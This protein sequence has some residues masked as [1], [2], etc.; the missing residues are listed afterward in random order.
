MTSS[1]MIGSFPA[2]LTLTGYFSNSTGSSATKCRWLSPI[3]DLLH[4]ADHVGKTHPLAADATP[5]QM[6][7][8]VAK[9]INKEIEKK[10]TGVHLQP[11]AHRQPLKKSHA[12]SLSVDRCCRHGIPTAGGQQM[13]ECSRFGGCAWSQGYFAQTLRP[14]S[15]ADFSCRKCTCVQNRAALVV[16]TS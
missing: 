10:M 12:D 4:S 7:D 3:I 14:K 13:P 2:V 16:M 9:E 11:E 6:T 8:R 1:E 15:E 5:W